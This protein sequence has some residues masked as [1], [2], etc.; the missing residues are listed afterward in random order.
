MGVDST[1]DNHGKRLRH[2]EGLE[3]PGITERSFLWIILEPAVGTVGQIPIPWPCTVI[4][5]KAVVQD[6]TSATYNI[7]HRTIPG[8]AGTDILT[9]DMVA[10][11]D[12]ETV[13]SGFND[14][15]LAEDNYLTV[16][17]S[18]VSGPVTDLTIRLKVRI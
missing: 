1:L 16:A 4:E 13:S 6:G 12:G 10:D 2:L 7:E 14:A 3:A 15:S 11:T 18:A 17:I 9:S 5:V 8:N